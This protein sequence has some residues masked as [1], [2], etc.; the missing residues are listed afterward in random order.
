MRKLFIGLVISTLVL[1]SSVA[2]GAV[3]I[4]EDGT[5]QG[6][7]VHIDMP[8]T[9]VTAFDGSTATVDPTP[10]VPLR[11]LDFVSV[12]KSATTT[13]PL[14]AISTPSGPSRT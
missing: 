11:I 1:L 8:S 2:Y 13:I 9:W 12:S 4:N 10:V 14:T 6:E 7:A 3:A 5:Y